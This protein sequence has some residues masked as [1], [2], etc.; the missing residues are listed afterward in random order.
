MQLYLQLFYPIVYQLFIGKVEIDW[1]KQRKGYRLTFGVQSRLPFVR[2]GADYTKRFLFK[3][4]VGAPIDS[5]IYQ[6]PFL[7]D[8]YGQLKDGFF[9]F[10]P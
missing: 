10:T 9:S 4:L 3:N 7:I 6:F 5:R 1:N 2:C 8:C